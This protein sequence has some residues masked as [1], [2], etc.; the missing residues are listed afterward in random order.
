MSALAFASRFRSEVCQAKRL[1][2]KQLEGEL[3]NDKT[4]NG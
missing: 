2:L 4:R 1:V 3:L